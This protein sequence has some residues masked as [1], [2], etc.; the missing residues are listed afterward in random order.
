MPCSREQK[1]NMLRPNM[2]SDSRVRVRLE[3]GNQSWR[4]S[5]LLSTAK[6]T[7]HAT[8][9]QHAVGSIF[10]S[11]SSG[12]ILP[13]RVADE[14]AIT[15]SHSTCPAPDLFW[16]CCR[17]RASLKQLYSLGATGMN[18]DHTAMRVEVLGSFAMGSMLFAS[19]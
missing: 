3:V 12:P 14:T 2:T 13:Q 19:A 11:G 17:T 8:K 15:W 1:T 10:V 18:L 5:I 9:K 16:P 4:V 6:G 7:T